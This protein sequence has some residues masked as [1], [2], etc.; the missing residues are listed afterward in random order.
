MYN[1]FC[2]KSSSS[3][4][5]IIK[6]NVRCIIS[7]YHKISL[8]LKDPAILVDSLKDMGYTPEIH[9]EAVSINGYGSSKIDRTAHIVVRKGQFGGY[10]DIGFE[11]ID[12]GYVMHADDYDC[13]V[14]GKKFNL[15]TLNKTYMEKKLNKYVNS[16]SLYNIASRR[17]N[18]KG[19]IE[20][21]LRV[22][23]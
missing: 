17:E 9:E 23:R 1:T 21:Q 18:N 14:H 15:E 19:Q 4:K 8:V 22:N 12:D 6:R 16:T 20:I 10:G 3:N 13:G 5:K 2:I 7:E 11:K